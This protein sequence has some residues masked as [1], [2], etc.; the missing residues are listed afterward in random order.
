MSRAQK[1]SSLIK[2]EAAGIK[3]LSVLWLLTLFGP[4][5]RGLLL[6]FMRVHLR[7]E[8][9]SQVQLYVIERTS[10]SNWGVSSS[11]STNP[12]I[13]RFSK[14]GT[15]EKGKVDQFEFKCMKVVERKEIMSRNTAA[16]KSG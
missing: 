1:Q 11:K 15:N 10:S 7:N 6:L 16:A 5:R 8:P 4:K 13:Y 9:H 3:T 12:A 14:K 2:Y